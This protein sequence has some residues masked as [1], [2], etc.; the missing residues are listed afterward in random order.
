MEPNDSQVHY[1][2]GNCIYVGI[3]NVST[4]VEKENKHQ[5]EPLGHH[6][7]CLEI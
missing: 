6:W 1:H 5:I 3:L 2:C 4:L 7:K